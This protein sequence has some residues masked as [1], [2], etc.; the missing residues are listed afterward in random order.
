MKKNKRSLL[1]KG[2]SQVRKRKATRKGA[3]QSL[4]VKV[5]SKKS[6]SVRRKIF[7][8][9]FLKWTALTTILFVVL[10]GSYRGVDR[11]LFESPKFSLRNINYQTDGAL[12][13]SRVLKDSGIVLG[14]NILR[15]DIKDAR[16]RIL[17]ELPMI[18]EVEIIREMP[19]DMTIEI[20]ERVP[21][22]WLSGQ[23]T[24]ENDFRILGGILLDDGGNAFA[25]E[26]PVLRFKSLPVI[27]SSEYSKVSPG[28]RLN[29]IPIQRGLEI[30]LDFKES[31]KSSP[32]AL[33]SLHS[34]NDFS[35][36]GYINTGAEITFGFDDI[37]R[38]V[39]DLKLLLAEATRRGRVL[40]E[41]NVMVKRNT[42]VKFANNF[43]SDSKVP[44]AVPVT[45][46]AIPT[47]PEREKK[48]KTHKKLNKVVKI[49]RAL[50]IESE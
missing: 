34:R 11:F 8:V 29:S 32:V 27:I 39:S 2:H 36:I 19:G 18:K 12:P 14:E 1:S 46:S 13:Q 50:P 49:P 3:K 47:K 38:Q 41:A 24:P 17:N 4:N 42:P 43:I 26:E 23:E 33:E 15:I 45:T 40:A 31:F 37:P 35:I 21:I 7:F 48:S 10:L 9:K 22:A 30:A 44:R 28:N 5:N 20:S 25:A 16:E 6:V